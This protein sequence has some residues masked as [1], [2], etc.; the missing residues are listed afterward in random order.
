[1]NLAKAYIAFIFFFL[2]AA[3]AA[4]VA[5]SATTDSGATVSGTATASFSAIMLPYV[6]DGAFLAVP[7][8][9]MR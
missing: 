1:M 7:P 3:L 6:L 4:V 2:G 9:V 8:T 5:V